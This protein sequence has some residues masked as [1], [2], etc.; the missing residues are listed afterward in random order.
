MSLSFPRTESWELVGQGHALPRSSA[1]VFEVRDKLFLPPQVARIAAK[2]PLAGHG[3]A[4]QAGKLSEIGI[5][6]CA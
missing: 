3:P 6:S 4:P 2:L 1:S 5:P